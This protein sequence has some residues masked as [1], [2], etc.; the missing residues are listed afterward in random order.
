MS[1]DRPREGFDRLERALEL[2]VEHSA[3]GAPD[4]ETLLRENQDLADLLEPLLAG[5]DE[6]RPAVELDGSQPPVL[7]EFR[8]IRELGR[9]GMGVVYEAWQSSLDRKVALK[10][11]APALVASPSAV[12]RFRRE[13]AAIGK[14]RHAGI[15]EIYS[16]GGDGERH[17]FAME[18]V[19]G[20]PLQRLSARAG[21][22]SFA[23]N[24]A[25]QVLEALSCAHRAGIVH[26]DVKPG[27]VLVRPDGT[28]VL[29]DFGLALDTALPS[30]TREGSFLGTLEYAAPEQIQGQPVDERSD[31]WSVGVVL[32]ELLAG[33]RPFQRETPASTMQ[34]ILRE[35]PRPLRRAR[36]NV[37]RDLAAIV[38]RALRKEPARRYAS[39]EEFLRDLR[40]WQSGGIVQARPPGALERAA[41]W[42]RREPWRATAV[43]I[44]LLTLPI[45]TGVL[46]YLAANA[47]RIAAAAEAERR[48]Q[49]EEALSAAWLALAEEDAPRGLRAL[50]SYGD[51]SAVDLEIA[52][53]RAALMRLDGQ[54]EHAIA[55]L[56]TFADQPAAQWILAMLRGESSTADDGAAPAPAAETAR[57]AVEHFVAGMLSYE[58]ARESSAPLPLYRAAMRSF[59]HAV[60]QSATPR[61]HYLLWWMITA[62]RSEDASAFDLAFRAYERH[63]PGSSGLRS[64]AL[65]CAS[66]VPIE[67]GLELVQGLD[68]ESDPRRTFSL[69]QL[70]ERAGRTEESESA[71]RRGLERSPRNTNARMNLAHLLIRTRRLEE[72]EALLLPALE[73]EPRNARLWLTIGSYRQMR[74]ETS[75][76]RE[77]L[78]QAI[79]LDPRAWSAHFNLGLLL[80]DAGETELALASFQLAGELDPTQVAV[81]ANVARALRKL[82]RYAEAV[83]AGLRSIQCAPHD[84]ATYTMTAKDLV[85]VGLHEAALQLA[86]RGTA[87]PNAASSDW[88]RLTE[89]LIETPE[90]DPSRAMAAAQRA[91]ELAG[92][93]DAA[94]QF[95]RARAEAACG[96]SAEAIARL[97]SLLQRKTGLSAGLRRQAELAL[98][99]FRA[100]N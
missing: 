55:A 58:R 14:L 53:A 94:A 47:P 80:Y 49:R 23:V 17:W 3:A 95:T 73:H 32:H 29:T 7:G 25:V 21:D 39:A 75:G 36:P 18:L 20:E 27:N 9:G 96:K 64:A 52:V 41:R 57:S 86:Q 42:M 71:Y 67:Q 68:F 61:A 85:R 66:S 26:R 45:L 74:G 12:A 83:I 11:L 65:Y 44:L 99:K 92:T 10:V 22:L 88:V 31:L 6:S 56:A 90:G 51:A 28:A 8:L 37:P 97:E 81:Q 54:L 40:A 33:Q 38:D 34:A 84:A 93:D 4:P 62:S 1:H 89:I 60:A 79:E 48:E 82:G 13:A 70:L 15:V 5:S 69:A 30:V 100:G 46:G 78:E 59:T 72:A 19:E 76:A 35:E 91:L 77:A 2:F 87:L 63:F 24:L 50:A 43:A 98:E 16:F